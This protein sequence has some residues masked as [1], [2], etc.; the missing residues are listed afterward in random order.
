LCIT[1]RRPWSLTAAATTSVGHVALE[2]ERNTPDIDDRGD[3]ARQRRAVEVVQ[4]QRR[5]LGRE[6]Q[7]GGPA[8]TAPRPGDGRDPT[9]ETT[10]VPVAHF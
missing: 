8:D 6:P 3:R 5:A 9:A 4:H 10:F 7:R 2:P 1:S